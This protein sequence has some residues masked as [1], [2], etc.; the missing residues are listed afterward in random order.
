MKA[1]TIVTVVLLLFVGASVVALVVQEMREKPTGGE[2]VEGDKVVAYY[3]HGTKRCKACRAIEAAAQ[4]AVQTR[5]PQ[6]LDDGRL[7]WRVANYEAP[8]NEALASDYQVMASTVV[9]VQWRDGQRARWENLE[10]EVW[11]NISDEAKLQDAVRQQV[12]AMLKE[13]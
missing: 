1:K 3:F 13:G 12:A 4:E 5:F 2:P 9:V 7:E 11:D 8:E 10:E 6:A